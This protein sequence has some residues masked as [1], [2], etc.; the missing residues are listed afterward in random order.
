MSKKS[1]PAWRQLAA[2]ELARRAAVAHERL[3]ACESCP[4]RCR[5]D[6]L[7]GKLGFCR[8]GALAQVASYGPHFGEEEPLVGR[9]GSGTIFFGNC[10]LGC[11]FCQNYDISHPHDDQAGG[12][13]VDAAALAGMMLELQEQG[14]VNINLVTPSHVVP[15]ILAALVEARRLGLALPLVYNTSSYDSLATLQLLAGVV[16]IYLADFKYW[17]PAEAKRLLRAEDYPQRA[18]EAIE[19]MH[20][21]VGDLQLDDQGLAHRGLLL[22][23][24]VMPGGLADS[25]AIF[26]FLA[27]KISP[28]TYTNIMEQYHPSGQAHQFPPI[29]R[30]LDRAE[31]QQALELAHR[32][33][34]HRLDERAAARLLRRLL[35]GGGG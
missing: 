26:H 17:R 18:R 9:G 22:R 2:D 7:A 33:G 21:Q 25:E 6:R 8:T 3:R 24:L 30:P 10:N 31:Y 14:C 1:I 5:V 4:R 29:D 23:H 35:R 16:D 13:E 20:R 32:A 12:M 34:L 11:V 27:Q 19:E 28:H 15:Q